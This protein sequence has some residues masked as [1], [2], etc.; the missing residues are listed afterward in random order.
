VSEQGYSPHHVAQPCPVPLER[1]L[2]LG[3]T[4][5][6]KPTV[7]QASL[8]LGE[9]TLSAIG[10]VSRAGVVVVGLAALGFL[11]LLL[12]RLQT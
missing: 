2:D 7:A 5:R 4:K 1:L 11:F 3:A 10:F 6:L 9:A 12:L 8:C